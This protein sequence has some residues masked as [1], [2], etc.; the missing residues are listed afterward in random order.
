[1]F[2]F[3][4]RTSLVSLV[5]E[6]AARMN[7][8]DLYALTFHFPDRAALLIGRAMD[9]GIIHKTYLFTELRHRNNKGWQTVFLNR[10]GEIFCVPIHAK[11]AILKDER[12]T[13]VVLSSNNWIND[14]VFEFSYLITG[15][16]AAAIFASVNELLFSKHILS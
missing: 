3:D 14:H 16:E 1:M 5:L 15:D 10:G 12:T 8:P 13:A 2:T 11:I 4:R 7:H 9:E 6:Q